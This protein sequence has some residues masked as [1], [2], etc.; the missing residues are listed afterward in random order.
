MKFM[1]KNWLEKWEGGRKRQQRRR[2]KCAF[3][4]LDFSPQKRG[5][6][7]RFCSATC[8][9]RAYERRHAGGDAATTVLAKDLD[10]RQVRQAIRDEILDI[11]L[12]AGIL[13]PEDMHKVRTPKATP[14]RQA[15][16]VMRELGIWPPQRRGKG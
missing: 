12:T 7:P 10:R 9:Q 15:D 8:R 3:C 4:G 11:L 5:R 2:A 16:V 13:R 14:G 1:A 6:L